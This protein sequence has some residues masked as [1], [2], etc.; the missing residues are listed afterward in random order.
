V[1]TGFAKVAGALNAGKAVGILHASDASADGIRKLQ[2][3]ARHNPSI[4]TDGDRFTSTQLSLS[5]G[6]T[7]VIHAALLAGRPSEIALQRIAALTRLLSPATE[8]ASV[9]EPFEPNAA[10]PAQPKTA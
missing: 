3:L 2:G 8:R 6:G 5:L 7:N 9:N 10:D 1:L 4:F